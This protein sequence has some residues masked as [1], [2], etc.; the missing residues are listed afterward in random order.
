MIHLKSRRNKMKFTKLT[1]AMVLIS[2]LS[3]FGAPGTVN[4]SQNKLVILPKPNNITLKE[5]LILGMQ[6][7]LWSEKADTVEGANF[8]VFPRLTAIAE[9]SWTYPNNKNYE[10]FE[11]RLK[12]F[13]EFY[14]AIG[15]NYFNPFDPATTPEFKC[16]NGKS[17]WR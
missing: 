2:C 5:N 8:R 4:N 6:G 7:C 14:D 1:M 10:D 3:L 11:R 9:A 15:V 17:P 12:S 13:L 16:N